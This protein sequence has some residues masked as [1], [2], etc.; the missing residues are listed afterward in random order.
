MVEKLKFEQITRIKWQDTLIT[1]IF[2][3]TYL[4]YNL[5]CSE[6]KIHYFGHL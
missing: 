6:S 1:N 4:N 2:Y 3:I 5:A